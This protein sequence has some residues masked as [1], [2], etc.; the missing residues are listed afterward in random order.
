MCGEHC[1]ATPF[2]A[3]SVGSSPHVRGTRGCVQAG[4][5]QRGIIP[6]CAGNTSSHRYIHPGAGDHP[7]MC[8][9]HPVT[10]RIGAMMQG[11]SPH[12]RGTLAVR[13]CRPHNGGIIPACAGNTGST[14]PP[15]LAT[16]DHP[17]MCGEHDFGLTLAGIEAGS[18]PHVRET[19]IVNTGVKIGIRIIPACAGNTDIIAFNGGQIK[20]HPRMCGEHHPPLQAAHRV[21][22]S[23]PHVRGTLASNGVQAPAYGI[24]PA[25]AGNTHHAAI[26]CRES[27]DHP[28]M[29]G[30]HAFP[31]GVIV[32]ASGSSP[33]VRGTLTSPSA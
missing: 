22:G 5:D 4:R 2:G 14:T 12:V 10:D 32:P 29:C 17:R 3:A 24:I 23:S 25:C 8:G 16:G 13:V 21:P 30:E 15:S 33:H 9:E 20:D 18:S 1:S 19:P 31:D 26:S 6:A 28:R 7:R 11:S 27:E